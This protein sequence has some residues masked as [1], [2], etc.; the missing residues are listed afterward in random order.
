[1]FK[2]LMVFLS[3]FILGVCIC[4][5][6]YYGLQIIEVSNQTINDNTIVFIR[7]VKERQIT[8]DVNIAFCNST[9]VLCGSIE[10]LLKDKKELVVETNKLIA[11]SEELVVTNMKLTTTVGDQESALEEQGYRIAELTTVNG[12]L[13]ETVNRQSSEIESLKTKIKDLEDQLNERY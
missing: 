5:G 6:I 12:S 10:S 8:N 11:R 4:S 7:L 2:V 13:N 3:T 9:E 1:M